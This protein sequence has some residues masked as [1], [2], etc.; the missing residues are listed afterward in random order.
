MLTDLKHTIIL[1]FKET[2]DIYMTTPIGYLHE[3]T[4]T[5]LREKNKFWIFIEMN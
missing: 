3:P 1:I 4:A 2:L 5:W